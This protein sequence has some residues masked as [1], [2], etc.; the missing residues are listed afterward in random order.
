[1]NLTFRCTRLENDG[2]IQL[3]DVDYKCD[4]VI[5]CAT[6]LSRLRLRRCRNEQGAAQFGYWVGTDSHHI[7]EVQSYF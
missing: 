3:H 5:Q 4:A 7:T 2:T 1:M 6:S